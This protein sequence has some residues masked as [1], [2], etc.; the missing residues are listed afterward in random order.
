[1]IDIDNFPKVY[2]PAAADRRLE[3]FGKLCIRLTLRNDYNNLRF[4]YNSESRNTDLCVADK[5]AYHYGEY[6]TTSI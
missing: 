5:T 3:A 2:A 6:T 1:M 4:G